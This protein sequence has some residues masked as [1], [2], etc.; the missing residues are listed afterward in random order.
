MS[1]EEAP[2]RIPDT[3]NVVEITEKGSP[4]SLCIG[5]RPVPEPR[6]G[7][8]LVRVAAAGVNRAD[9]LQRQGQYPPPRGASDVLGLELSGVVCAIGDGETDRTVD[10]EICALVTGGA[11]AEYAVVPSPQC[12]PRPKSSSLVDAAALP[13]AYCTV[14]DN[15]FERGRL[16][17]G[18]DFLVHGGSSGI[19]TVAIQLAKW[20]GARVFTTVGSAEKCDACLALGADQAVNYREE[21]FVEAIR[22]VNG[23][24]G[25]DVILDMVGETYLNRNLDLLAVEGRLVLI[26][27]MEGSKA[28]F[29]LLKLM[30]RRLTLTGS[31]LRSRTVDEKAAVVNNVL[32][33]VW[34]SLDSGDLTPVIH[35]TYPLDQAAEAHNMM[36]SS[37]HIGKLLLIP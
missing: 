35:A 1:T 3:M 31:T 26:G 19:G 28:N 4:A 11:Y 25:V 33:K 14:W 15:V 17:S 23:S 6:P 29:N 24:R 30:S 13:E 27:L 18:D 7:E 32:A 9:V 5:R 10:E 2:L 8:V 16:K 20:F 22:E 37:K 34:P 21:D 36:E 12:L